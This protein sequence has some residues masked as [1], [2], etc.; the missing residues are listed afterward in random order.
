MKIKSSKLFA[1][2]LA[3]VLVFGSVAVA[4]SAANTDP[5]VKVSSV[6]NAEIGAKNQ[7]I[8]ISLSPDTE[9]V[10]AKLVLAGDAKSLDKVSIVAN[11]K[12]E[13][14]SVSQTNGS[15]TLSVSKAT[16]ASETDELVLATVSFDFQADAKGAVVL[17]PTAGSI[18]DE[19]PTTIAGADWGLGKV[20]GEEGEVYTNMVGLGLKDSIKSAGKAAPAVD[21][22]AELTLV[23]LDGKEYTIEV[24][25]K[26]AFHGNN[27]MTKDDF[28]KFLETNKTSIAQKIQK[29]MNNTELTYDEFEFDADSLKLNNGE[30]KATD[31]YDEKAGE[32]V[33]TADMIQCEPTKAFI[34]VVFRSAMDSDL[35][36]GSAI[37][38][39]IIPL[40]VH[41]GKT[42]YSQATVLTY[43]KN[44]VDL[45]NQRN[46]NT[47]GIMIDNCQNIND[48]IVAT[49]A[50][51]YDLGDFVLDETV[52]AFNNAK[53][54][55][56]E[57][58]VEDREPESIDKAKNV[59]TVYF[60]QVNVPQ[61]VLMAAAEA[62]GK[63]DYGQFADA[64][65]L[66]IN[67][68]IGAFQAFCDSL[69]NA[70]WPSAE[71]VEEEEDK[72]SS[73]SPKTGA[74]IGLGSALA[75]VAALSATAVAIVR[76]KED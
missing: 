60:D 25:I 38:D 33:Y 66:T 31:K 54:S 44:H 18:N 49:S 64:Y 34:R 36:H 40:N 26:N 67:E 32:Y 5:Y 16:N 47:A 59:Y 13:G 76:K 14:I 68:T 45:Y 22:K 46:G 41:A 70:E 27:V 48:H 6:I 23:A 29:A 50:G 42:V 57:K 19:Q 9:L 71:D 20:K 62:F 69:V 72:D 43:I 35:Y 3:V 63:I 21:A 4:A 52:V 15:V 12:V 28:V 24:E 2:L 17:T 56:S 58:Y 51:K 53:I 75:V 74:F 39:Y 73:D 55:G 11:D 7:K 65:V 30:I 1:L 61:S 10:N 8:T 37:P